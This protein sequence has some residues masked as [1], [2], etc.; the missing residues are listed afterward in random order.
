MEVLETKT[1][2]FLTFM[3]FKQYDVYEQYYP[4]KS[5]F[6]LLQLEIKTNYRKKVEY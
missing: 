1:K 4:K 2:T 3:Q 6:W 5:G